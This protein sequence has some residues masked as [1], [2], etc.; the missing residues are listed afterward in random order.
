MEP[1]VTVRCRQ[2]DHQLV[3]QILP[4]AVQEYQSRAKKDVTVL[5]DTENWLPAEM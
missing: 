5:I 3:E 2:V 4:A 1:K